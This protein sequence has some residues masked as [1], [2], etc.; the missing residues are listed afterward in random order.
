MPRIDRRRFLQGGAATAAL[1]AMPRPFA[2]ALGVRNAYGAGPANPI[3]V[4]VQLGGGNDGLNTVIPLDD[5]GPVAQRSLYEAARPTLAVPTAALALT[6]I[7][8][9]PVKGTG[10]ALHPSMP[11]LK[12]LY[13]QG[14]V[15][16]LNGIGYP[17]PSLSHFRSE[18]IW[19]GAE[20]IGPFPGGWL[21]RYLDT[22]YTSSDLVALD[23]DSTLNPAFF[24]DTA[25]VLAVKKLSQFKLPDD[26]VFP[27]AVARRLALDTAYASEAD[28]LQTAG[29]QQT[30]GNS[31]NVLLGKIDEFAAIDRS[32]GSN[33][34]SVDDKF[35][36]RL[37]EI[38]SVIRH[39]ELIGPPVG[40]RYFHC[41]R[42][43]FDT[44]TGQGALAG[45]QADLLA[46][47]SQGLAAF[48]Q[49]MVDIGVE[50]RVLIVTMSEFG[51]RVEENGGLG[52]DHGE[53]SCLF[54][55]GNTVQG[56]VHGTV[57][58][59]DDLDRGNLKFHTDFRSVYATI[60]DRWLQS[61]GAHTALLPG[62]PYPLLDFLPA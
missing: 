17:A 62:A 21:G 9:D 5:T 57:P 15:A 41:R 40:V 27:D 31:G 13:D 44:H 56:G 58:A 60:I 48:W 61:P 26:S 59:L 25:N 38:A 45:R 18:D 52:T 55:I 33:L 46:A 42:G 16:V 10:L 11:E 20:N 39:D 53:A 1:A 35:A 54:A 7:D 8:D 43:G 29:L 19:F 51:R 4:F 50:D 32:W 30:I 47:V 22:Y 34:E 23:A 49:D 24:G 28:P 3:F 36:D 6:R 2:G 12:A 37:L 14:R